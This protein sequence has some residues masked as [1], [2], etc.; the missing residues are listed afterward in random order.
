ML[1]H[2]VI[3]VYEGSRPITGIILQLWTTQAVFMSSLHIWRLATPHINSADLSPN[4]PQFANPQDINSR[5]N[6]NF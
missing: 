3:T 6:L 1:V 2:K 4:F 5:Y